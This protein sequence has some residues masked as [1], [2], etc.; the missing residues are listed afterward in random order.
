MMKRKLFSYVAVLLLFVVFGCS[1]TN[2]PK[3]T[4][5]GAETALKITR[6]ELKKMDG[7][8]IETL[9]NPAKKI[10]AKDTEED[11]IKIEVTPAEEGVSVTYN[12]TLQENGKDKFAALNLGNNT[13]T[14]TLRKGD[15]KTEYT[16][17][18]NL[19]ENEKPSDKTIKTLKIGAVP[20]YQSYERAIEANKGQ[21]GKYTA[22]LP[23]S[24]AR[25][26]YFLFVEGNNLKDVVF[27]EGITK[28]TPYPRAD[29]RGIDFGKDEKLPDEGGNKE[30]T[31][32]IFQ[33]DS[34]VTDLS[35]GVKYTV[36]INIKP[37]PNTNIAGIT[38]NNEVGIIDKQNITCNA[39]F[40]IGKAVSV[41][42]TLADATSRWKMVD[43]DEDEIQ[44]L[45]IEATGADFFINV[46][47]EA[48][49]EFKSKY[50]VTL[51]A[52]KGETEKKITE[53]RYKTRS[54]PNAEVKTATRGAGDV[55]LLTYTGGKIYFE[56]NIPILKTG[57]NTTDVKITEIQYKDENGQY[58][59]KL[60][61]IGSFMIDGEAINKVESPEGL[62]VRVAFTDNKA[63]EFII[64]KQQ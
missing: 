41:N 26:P 21:D 24:V 46:I 10:T 11:R 63:D 34:D 13:F 5:S 25:K 2:N 15:L 4:N 8:I 20:Y 48:G 60:K 27:I 42:V 50:H 9:E 28:S 19:K 6:L 38:F 51:K 31:F 61:K 23:H 30:F 36:I 52:K 40:E 12:P 47:P 32:Y 56:T 29:T 14:I 16:L 18:I 58:T 64:K 59:K 22:T 33:K 37:I 54:T 1:G 7:M 45:A 55:F 17:E 35:K 44:S 3:G 62:A 49:A 57:E 39:E 53:I 43:K